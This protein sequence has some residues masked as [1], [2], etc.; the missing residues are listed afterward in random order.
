V[1]RVAVR[2]AMPMLQCKRCGGEVVQKSRHQ[3]ALVGVFMLASVGIGVL[4][5]PSPLWMG[6]VIFGLTGVYLLAWASIGKGRWC[7]GCKRFDG[8]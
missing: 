6:S 3:L 1:D 8:V 2:W 4:S 7:R 5:P